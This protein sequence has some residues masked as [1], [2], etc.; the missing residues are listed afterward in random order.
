MV[1]KNNQLPYVVSTNAWALI[2][3]TLGE[4]Q[5]TLIIWQKNNKPF[6]SRCFDLN[7]RP[8]L[9]DIKTEYEKLQNESGE[10]TKDLICMILIK[11]QGI[12]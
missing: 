8:N 1:Y 5:D 12:L 6:F 4:Y 10:V 2:E 9:V 11:H 3:K 7:Y